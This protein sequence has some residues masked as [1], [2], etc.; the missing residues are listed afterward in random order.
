LFCFEEE[1][2]EESRVRFVER[3]EHAVQQEEVRF[4]NQRACGEEAGALERGEGI[5][6]EL[7][8]GGEADGAVGGEAGQVERAQHFVGTDFFVSEAEV[9][10]DGAFDDF[11]GAQEEGVGTEAGEVPVADVEAVD[12]GGAAGLGAQAEEDIGEEGCGFPFI[13]G[14]GGFLSGLKEDIRHC[15]GFTGGG[16]ND[17]VAGFDG[18]RLMECGVFA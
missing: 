18:G 4:L 12:A 9:I 11:E 6:S 3:V 14:E 13:G 5:T 15:D 17:E 7:E 1:R 8:V 16:G 10:G 2:E